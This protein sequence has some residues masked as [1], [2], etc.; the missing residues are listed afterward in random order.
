MATAGVPTISPLNVNSSDLANEYKVWT[1]SY[2]FYEEAIGVNEKA[3]GVRRATF[4]HCLGA[5]VQRIF[6]TLTGDKDT[7]AQA[8]DVLKAYFNPKKNV[9]GE[10][11]KFRQKAQ[12]ASEP[13]DHYVTSLRELAKSL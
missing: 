12:S 13:I 8:K 7:F 3:D 5:P 2:E 1:D 6:A 4:L 10:R 9:P 11:H